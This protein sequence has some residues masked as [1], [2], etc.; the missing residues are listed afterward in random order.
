ML[1]DTSGQSPQS[2]M[3]DLGLTNY[4][5]I[6]PACVF[7]NPF[8]DARYELSP[9]RHSRIPGK[10]EYAVSLCKLLNQRQFHHT[11]APKT[12]AVPRVSGLKEPVSC[13]KHQPAFQIILCHILPNGC[14]IFD[15]LTRIDCLGHPY[16][17][18]SRNSNTFPDQ[19]HPQ[20]RSPYLR[21]WLLSNA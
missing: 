7:S 8:A 17:H 20:N 11:N 13:N 5:K 3:T 15:C 2:L 19:N 6:N 14:Q 1:H 10:K 16:C 12:K 9:H 18:F 21:Q 4:Q